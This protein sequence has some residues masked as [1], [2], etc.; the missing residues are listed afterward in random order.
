MGA[1]SGAVSDA[2]KAGSAVAAAGVM[3]GTVF[4]EFRAVECSVGFGDAV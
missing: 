1:M 3:E 4:A 2:F